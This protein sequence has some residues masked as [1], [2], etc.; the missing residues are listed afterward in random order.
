MGAALKAGVL[1]FAI[2]M[3]VGF[4]MGAARELVLVPRLGP[5]G[6]VLLE[7]P[8]ML[9][10][11]WA[12]CVSAIRIFNVSHATFPRLVMGF[13]AFA[14]LIV[15]EF[16][17]ANLLFGQAFGTALAR[18]QTVTGM[19]GLAAQFCFAVMPLI[20]SRIP[21]PESVAHPDHSVEM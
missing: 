20:V 16:G 1:Y 9:A 8:V 10:A 4:V 6:A 15:A 5:I 12:V 11:S 3:T 7:I 13:A 17:F 2:I 18:Y 21:P 19:I 14:L